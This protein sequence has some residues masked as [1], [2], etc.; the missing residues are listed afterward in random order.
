MEIIDTK[1]GDFSLSNDF[2][3]S[4]ESKLKDV[5]N[6]FGEA[7][8]KQSPYIKNCYLSSQL[9]I[10]ELYFKFILYFENDVLKKI[11]FEIEQEAKARTPWG[12]NRDFE[13][14]WIA[15]QLK[16]STNFNW[17]TAQPG[18]HYHNSYSWGTIG[19]YFDFKNGTY[20]SSINYIF[21]N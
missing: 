20:T 19:I 7:N 11:Q 9:K 5:I 12:N 3:L 14:R 8:F 21:S 2:V 18:E 16:D 6:F 17:D 10:D 13:T 1:K 4:S 15:N